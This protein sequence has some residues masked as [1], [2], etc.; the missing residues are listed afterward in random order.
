MATKRTVISL[1]KAN[2]DA[3]CRSQNV[4][5]ATV[6]NAL[7]GNSGSETAQQIRRLAMDVYGGLTYTKVIR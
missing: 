2:I 6:Y 5:R 3:L 7:N 4:S 1:T